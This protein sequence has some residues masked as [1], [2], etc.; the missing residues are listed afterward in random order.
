MFPRRRGQS[1]LD[2]LEQNILGDI[3]VSVDAINDANQIDTH[4]SSPRRARK[5]RPPASW[6]PEAIK[7]D[8]GRKSVPVP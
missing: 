2:S 5:C 6:R 8:I 3:L 1:R 4:S 7:G